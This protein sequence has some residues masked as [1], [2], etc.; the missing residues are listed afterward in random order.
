MSQTK[1]SWKL[2]EYVAH[3]NNVNCV[4]LS[5]K[6]G[7]VIVTG[8]EDR[9][10]NLWI[11]GKP[12]CLMS[13]CGHTTPVES[14][15]FGH[16]EEMVVAGSMSGALKV[17]DL[18]QAKIMRTLTGHTS[19]IKSLDF[20][21]Y[22]DY[23]TSGSLDCNVKL[24]DIRKKGCIYTYRGHKNGVNC[25]RFSPDGKWI[26]S[27]GEDSVVKIW[28]ITAGKILTDL[29]YHQGPVN[30]VEFHPNELLLASGSSDRTVKFW[31]LENFNMVSTTDG[32]STPVRNI[33]F[34]PDGTCLFS[35]TK[36][37]LKVYSWEPSKCYDSIPVNWGEVADMA[38]GQNQLIGASFS[39]TNVST[40][41][42]DLKRVQPFGGI[43]HQEIGSNLSSKDVDEVFTDLSI[44]NSSVSEGLKHVPKEDI[45]EPT[46]DKEE[47][48]NDSFEIANP[49]DYR[50]IFRP[51]SRLEHSPTRPVEP[52][53]P[54]PD[55]GMFQTKR[56]VSSPRNVNRQLSSERKCS[57]ERKSNPLRK[58]QLSKSVSDDGDLEPVRQ[59]APTKTSK[60]ASKS[61][62]K[63]SVKP[64]S[65]PSPRQPE[66][67]K[68]GISPEDFL[69]KAGG[70]VGYGVQ[71]V[72]SEGEA[73]S[74]LSSGHDAMAKVLSHR[75]KNLQI[76]RAMWTSGNT[77]AA[78]DSAISMKDPSVIVDLL[79]VLNL[80]SGL[81]SLDLCSCLLPQV[82]DL[83]DSKY[84][85]YVTAACEALKIMLKNF[86]PVIKSNLTAPPSQGVD[87]SREERYRK[88]RQCYENLSMIRTTISKRMGAPGKIGQ[89]LREIQIL[90]ASMD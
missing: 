45:E 25:V 52:F 19:S 74:T 10:V 29:T 1:R 13:L 14:V 69:P 27:A 15:R 6:S 80:K 65:K 33:L 61:N 72:P 28:D 57:A 48:D 8:G 40:F 56:N 46:Q 82:Q 42:V 43:P 17:W 60:V 36:D 78:V 89:L 64:V 62:N 12:N 30:I 66:E 51:K 47:Q 2:Q 86:G 3:G 55:D 68:S 18:E 32:D 73:L 59:P 5:R 4:A 16:E 20:H 23:C 63:T 71:R 49:E 9:K 84:D 85:S 67:D 24:W 44:S 88:C 35:G 58:S 81:W 22:G 26:A 39:Q 37:L 83:M 21:P 79:N 41:V 7:R 54:P 50:E 75:S 76:V 70:D 53:Q 11:V 34:H 87:I 31:D 38:I 77:K 90:M